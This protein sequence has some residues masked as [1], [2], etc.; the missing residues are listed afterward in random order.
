[1]QVIAF[2]KVRRNGVVPSTPV[3]S[4]RV[5]D[6]TAVEFDFRP[7]AANTGYLKLD[8]YR[9]LCSKSLICQ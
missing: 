2:R 3:A 8:F 1:M 9:E 7:V 5:A 4:Y 6:S